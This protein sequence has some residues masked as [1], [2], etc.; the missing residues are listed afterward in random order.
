MGLS[1]ESHV[2]T[3]KDVLAIRHETSLMHVFTLV[4][5]HRGQIQEENHLEGL[6]H[7][8]S[9]EAMSQGSKADLVNALVKTGKVCL[10]QLAPPCLLRIWQI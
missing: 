7:F 2:W 5:P 8:R 3:Q 4:W 9:T 6:K 10:G 1:H